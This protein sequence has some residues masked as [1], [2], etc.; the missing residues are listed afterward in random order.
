MQRRPHETP[1][2]LP[3]E[4]IPV[5][6]AAFLGTIVAGVAGIAVARHRLRIA[7]GPVHVQLLAGQ[8]VGHAAAVELHH[9]GAKHVAVEAIRRLEIRR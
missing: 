7:P 3:P 2:E 1:R 4:G 8:A 5:G 9:L 6:R